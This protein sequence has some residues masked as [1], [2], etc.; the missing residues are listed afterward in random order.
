MTNRQTVP[1]SIKEQFYNLLENLFIDAELEGNSGYINLM[2]AR[3]Q[4][5]KKVIIPAIDK[6]ID[7][8]RQDAA[9]KFGK[10]SDE[11][12]V[13]ENAIYNLLYTFYNRYFTGSSIYYNNIHPS[14]PAI[15]EPYSKQQTLT[16]VDVS[17]RQ[18]ETFDTINDVVLF[19]KTNG[20]YYI[21]SDKQ[22]NS[23]DI[24]IENGE[25][26]FTF[27]FDVSDLEHKVNN[28]KIS[29]VYEF[30]GIEKNKIIIKVQKSKK[31]KKTKIDNI[32]KNINMPEVDVELIKKAIAKFKKQSEVDYF[33]HKNAR[34]FL[35]NEL[36]LFISDA[37]SQSEEPL[38]D[39][40][41]PESQLVWQY[42]RYIGS[43]VNYLV[44]IFENELAKMWNKPRFVKNSHYVITLDRIWNKGEKGKEVVKEIVKYL[45]KQKEQAYK[46]I[47]ELR[48]LN[49]FIEKVSHEYK[50][51][52]ADW[53]VMGFINEDFNP[54]DILK[55]ETGKGMLKERKEDLNPQYKYLPI[56]TKY[57]PEEFEYKILSLFD[58]L[59]EELDGWAIKSENY[60][61]LNTILPKWR[62]KVQT[63]YIDPPFN[64]S[65]SEIAYINTYRDSSW[66]SMIMNRLEIAKDFMN[67]KGIIIVAIDDTECRYLLCAMEELFGVNN[68]VGVITTLANPQGR[69]EKFLSAVNEYNLIYAKNIDHLQGLSVLKKGRWTNLK[70]TGTNSRREE[71]PNRFFPILEK[72]GKLYL[73]K[74][75][76]YEQLY[77]RERKTFNDEYLQTLIAKYEAEGYSV[78]LPK[79]KTGEYLVWQRTFERVYRELDTYRYENGNIYTPPIVRKT[80]RT[81]WVDSK[82]SN[83]EYGTELL[84]NMM[85]E[86]LSDN[87][88]KSVYTVMDMCNLANAEIILDFF[89]GSGTTAHAVM[90]LN[91]EDS[92]K[93]KFIV[94]EMGDHFNTVLLPRIKKVAYSLNWKDGKPIPPD[95]KQE[96]PE[97]VSTF[98]KYYELEQF[99]EILR[100]VKY[101][102]E[103]VVPSEATLNAPIVGWLE[104]DIAGTFN[105]KNKNIFI[106]QDK[107]LDYVHITEDGIEFII[108]HPRATT[109]DKENL[110]KIDIA[111]TISNLIGLKIKRIEKDDKGKLHIV[112]ENNKIITYPFTHKD[113]EKFN[114]SQ[115]VAWK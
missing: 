82:Y 94:I 84:K 97:G 11:I 9:K 44:G 32:V 63:I 76:E 2:N 4:F 22:W 49:S 93:R 8:F 78:I 20:L 28:E 96:Y 105:F 104:T 37:L 13:L 90:K 114:L 79:S 85:G 46:E 17:Q 73:I 39:I 92:G 99:E 43:L 88:P 10:N 77:D 80:P 91:K 70:R 60:Q 61:A 26:N 69:V 14:N 50:T 31:G 108:E 103:F 3:S 48:K 23:M 30:G 38:N 6:S 109:K 56:D 75:D 98:V 53:Y 87:T 112:F 18:Y 25:K 62:E 74:R 12:E 101:N 15:V 45:I 40:L 21:K 71:R 7:K 107:L 55:V 5:Y 72:N 51:L 1:V 66:L 113:F 100:R 35:D 65:S 68:F 59:D 33:I 57:L 95:K 29:L 86:A 102:P 24:V 106:F 36:R 47:T 83:P 16:G 81:I 52:I 111:E 89:A 64:T 19:W 110:D 58:N 27:H 41:N 54:N 34:G 67:E 115:L 42:V